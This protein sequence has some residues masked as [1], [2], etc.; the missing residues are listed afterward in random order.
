M[1]EELRQGCKKYIRKTA[2]EKIFS[3]EPDWRGWQDITDRM[4]LDGER[5]LVEEYPIYHDQEF[6]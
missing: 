1:E 6:R 2:E 3:V 4:Q 5:L